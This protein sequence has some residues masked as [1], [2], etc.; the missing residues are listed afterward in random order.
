VKKILFIFNSFALLAI[1]VVACSGVKITN[2]QNK[3]GSGAVYNPFVQQL[4]PQYF[5]FNPSKTLSRL[6]IK[7]NLSELMFS[8]IGANR[9]YISKVKIEY[10]IFQPGDSEKFVDTASVVFEIKKRKGENSAIT[11]I[12]LND[13]GLT[14][15]NLQINT[16]DLFKQSSAEDYI[17]VDRED[18]GNS[19]N[20]LINLNATNYPYFSNFFDKDQSFTI[21]YNRLVDSIYIRYFGS[22]VPLPAPPFSAM[23]RPELFSYAD[24]TW[25]VS[26]KNQFDF[27]QKKPGLYYFQI[28]STLKFGMGLLNKGND[29]PFIKWSEDLLNPLEYLMSTEEFKAIKTSDNKKLSVDKFWLSC[30]KN[31]TRAR[32][33]IRIFYTRTFY[34]NLYFTSF[35][36]GWRTDRGMIYIMFGPPKSVKKSPDKEIWFYYDKSNI[37]YLQFI[38]NKY[39]NP[40]TS[41]DYI[42]ERHIDFK[43]F[44]FQAIDSWKAGKVYTVFD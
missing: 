33:L 7:L 15:F 20:F 17:T 12:N 26:G 41:N 9:S 40:Y 18:E 21:Q 36:E 27:S 29:Y 6:Y 5:V 35:T 4:H 42:L 43:T 25:S 28:D 13:K 19:Q 31:P 16:R 39:A 32:E 30:G 1:F 10:K 44:W 23:S 37:K 2:N 11:Y 8:P 34:A 3:V 22:K 24:S 14:K 38:F